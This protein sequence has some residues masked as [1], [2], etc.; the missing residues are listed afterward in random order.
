M[1]ERQI[2]RYLSMKLFYTP[3]NS[4]FPNCLLLTY[5]LAIESYLVT[6]HM[7]GYSIYIY[8]DTLIDIQRLLRTYGNLWM[9]LLFRQ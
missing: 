6:S 5:M 7:I 9:T 2:R 3:R 8:T 4:K 1:I